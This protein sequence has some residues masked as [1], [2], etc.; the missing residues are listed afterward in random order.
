LSLR[1]KNLVKILTTES[2]KPQKVYKNPKKNLSKPF[3]PPTKEIKKAVPEITRNNLRN[4]HGTRT[5]T[6]DMPS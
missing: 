3:R 6:R 1:T 5:N 2:V 4:P